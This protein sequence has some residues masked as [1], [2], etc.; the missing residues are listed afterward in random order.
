MKWDF[1]NL[2]AYHQSTIDNLINL[3][4][5]RTLEAFS[6][7]KD[8]FAV[9]LDVNGAFDNVNVDIL[10][11][12]LAT[13]GCPL[14]LIKFI[15]FLTHERLI[16]TE[17]NGE[18]IRI[19]YKGV[20]QGGVLSPLL[21]NIYV[22]KICTNLLKS[23]TVLQFADDIA[24]YCKRGTAK[25]C[26]TLLER[27]INTAYSNLYAIGLELSPHKTVFVHFNRRNT[28][29]GEMEILVNKTP[30]KSSKS[31]RF[32]G[33]IFDYRLLFH[34]QVE[35]IHKKVSRATNI[36][37]FLRGT[38]WGSN[39]STLLILYKSFI[40]SIIDYGCFI[41]FP[42]QISEKQ[43]LEKL[44]YSAIRLAMSYRSSTP[45]NILLAESKLLFI[46]DQA[47]YLCKTYLYKIYSNNL[48]PVHKT[49]LTLIN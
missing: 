42:T 23:V 27:A 32:L 48:L 36:V 1:S 2:Y 29:S 7:K 25:S 22:S 4:L 47:T 3:T 24:L 18:Q 26:K 10:L 40:R 38:W 17:T 46:E 37:K 28:K 5:N 11:Q 34:E 44:Q 20:P 15:K 49:Y 21:Y 35:S 33:I 41:Y 16:F 13:I 31:A 14:K 30:I 6:N 8:L 45:T 39:L 43:R 12:Q 9:F 19:V